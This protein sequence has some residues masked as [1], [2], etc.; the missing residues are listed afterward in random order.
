LHHLFFHNDRS[1]L[2]QRFNFK[3]D[4][5]KLMDQGSLINEYVGRKNVF[6]RE[7]DVVRWIISCS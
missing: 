2:T 7:S 3:N 5:V 4:V 1:R 6:G